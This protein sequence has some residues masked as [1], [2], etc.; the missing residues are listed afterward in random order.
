MGCL[1]IA[2]FNVQATERSHS[3]TV[4]FVYPVATGDFVIGFDVN[5]PNCTNV[6][7]TKFM[8]VTVGEYGVTAEGSKKMYAAVLLALTARHV[9]S[10]TFDDSTIYCYINRFT[11]NS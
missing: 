10:V 7:A 3:S 8:Y 9:L 1:I 4:K 6:G 2:A 11:I 5:A